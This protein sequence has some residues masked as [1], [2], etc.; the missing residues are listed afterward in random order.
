M[1][2]ITARA[3]GAAT[4][5]ASWLIAAPASATIRPT[6]GGGG[7]AESST[8]CDPG[9][10][11]VG[12]RGN[13]GSWVDSLAVVCAPLRHDNTLGPPVP[14]ALLGGGGGSPAESMCGPNELV[15]E[16]GFNFTTNRQVAGIGFTCIRLSNSQ[17]GALPAYGPGTGDPDSYTAQY[18]PWGE[19]VVGFHARYG[20]HVNALGTM[21][22]ALELPEAPKPKPPAPKLDPLE[23]SDR[24]PRGKTVEQCAV[25]K[26]RQ[27][28]RCMA[29]FG[30]V[31][32]GSCTGEAAQIF[33][34]CQGFAAQ[35]Q[36][37]AAEI[38]A[39][40]DPRGKSIEQCAVA[41]QRSNAR[42]SQMPF[43]AKPACDIEV[44]QI[45]GVCQGLAA[46]AAASSG[47]QAAGR[48]ARVELPVEVFDA[49]NGVGKVI[50][51]LAAESIVTIV[52]ELGDDWFEVAGDAVPGGRGF[53]YSGESYRSLKDE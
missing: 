38:A 12:L 6:V 45:F 4:L 1:S 10:Y 23:V 47:G 34:V 21:C 36:V 35:A 52:A 14:A 22:L 30:P 9:S 32:M 2:K 26:Q 50:G 20:R 24:D 33:G 3:L 41:L 25:A 37:V 43:T 19:R 5:L 8:K 53:V 17:R 18:C 39:D 28:A 13:T 11:V 49:P 51:E 7:D 46:Q 29:R 15:S 16:V 31:Q 27:D 42:C 44:G 40:R 48:Q